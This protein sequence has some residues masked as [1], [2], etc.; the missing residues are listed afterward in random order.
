MNRRSTFHGADRPLG[1][2]READEVMP[3]RRQPCPA[4]SI[5][6]MLVQAII[7]R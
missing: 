3:L 4:A 7:R 6:R 5:V 1:Q 2:I